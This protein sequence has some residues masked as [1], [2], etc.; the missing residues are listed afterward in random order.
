MAIEPKVDKIIDLLGSE[1]ELQ[2]LVDGEG[3]SEN[4]G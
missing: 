1:E 3:A 4:V 2:N